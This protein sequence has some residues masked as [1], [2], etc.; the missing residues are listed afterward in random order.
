LR[1]NAIKDLFSEIGNGEDFD[2]WFD[3]TLGHLAVRVGGHF[4]AKDDI[5]TILWYI[6]GREEQAIDDALGK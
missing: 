3:E 1:L 4:Y 2:E 6:Y 5:D